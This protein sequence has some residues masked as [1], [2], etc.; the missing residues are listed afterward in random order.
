MTESLALKYIKNKSILLKLSL[1]KCKD[2]RISASGVKKNADEIYWLAQ[3]PAAADFSYTSCKANDPYWSQYLLLYC[4][5]AKALHETRYFVVSGNSAG[6]LKQPVQK[7]AD[8]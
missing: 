5:K 6:R 1:R 4:K 2:D 8:F 3:L 7:C